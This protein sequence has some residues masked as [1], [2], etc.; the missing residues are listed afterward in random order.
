MPHHGRLDPTCDV[1]PVNPVFTPPRVL[2]YGFRGV[3]DI[4]GFHRVLL[5]FFV[6][7]YI[8]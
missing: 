4:C 8:I 2:R 5:W 7:W 3:L 1:I 6:K